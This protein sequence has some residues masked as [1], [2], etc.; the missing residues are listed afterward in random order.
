[1]ATIKGCD[2]FIDLLE[3]PLGT[4]TVGHAAG[5]RVSWSGGIAIRSE[6]FRSLF[7]EYNSID[8]WY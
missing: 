8:H 3:H 7:G 5:Y 1:M 4:M 6:Q 2:L